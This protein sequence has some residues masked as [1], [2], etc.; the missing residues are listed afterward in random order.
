M[1][2]I[3]GKPVARVDARAKVTGA[4]V[5]TV[6]VVRPG[7]VHAAI[8][9]SERAHA[10]I[11]SIDTTE[12]A[13][14]P[15]V[16]GVFT[17]EHLR[18][19]DPYY[20]HIIR[21]HPVLAVDKVRFMGE[22]IAIVVASTRLTARAAAATVT[23]EYEDLEPVIGIDDAVRD[24]APLVHESRYRRGT[25]VAWETVP[26]DHLGT[27]V[28]HEAHLEWGDV[29]AALGA[30]DLTV[31]TTGTYPMLYA[32]AM[33]PYAAV[34]EYRG[35]QLHVVS[36]TQ[37]P[38]MVR[39]EL[40]RIF[41]VPH[42]QVQVEAP[43]VGGG[44]GSKSWTKV[45][46]LAAV[47]AHLTG[48]AVRIGLTVEE[49]M[50]TTRADSARVIVST[51]LTSDGAIMARDFQVDFNTGAYADSSPSILDKAV[52]RCFGP[53]RIPNLRIH[54]RLLYTNTVPASS[55]RG[56]GAPQGNLAGEYNLDHA[57]HKLGIDPGQLRRRNLAAKGDELLPKRRPLDADIAADLDLLLTS[58]QRDPPQVDAP[59]RYG[60]GFGC[61]ASD[62]GAFPTSTAMVRI[63]PDGSVLVS[64]GAVEIGQGS[65]TVLSQIVA[66]ELGL[67]MDAVAIAQSSTIATPFERTT[68]GSRTTTLVGLAVLR[69]A[70][71]ALADLRR[72]AAEVWSCGIDLVVAS[73]GAL[74]GP[75]GRAAGYGDVVTSWFGI[76]GGEAI[77][78]GIVRPEGETKAMPPFWEIGVAG[79]GLLVD[80]ETG[81]VRVE[82]LAT[83]G[84]VGFAINP[85][86]MEGQDLG[87]AT[88]GLGAALAE[89]LEYDGG[90]LTNPNLVDYRVPRS[91]DMPS[92]I[93]T[94]LAQR[95]D[96][97][98]PYGAKGGGEGS[99]NPI[100][101]AVMSAIARATGVWPDDVELPMT[102]E[103]VWRLMRGSPDGR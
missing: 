87:A 7:M 49:A 15:D 2:R 92:I 84:D 78:I 42:S 70:Q 58:L 9:R 83:V 11:R 98:G 20:G 3:V 59:Y 5:Y 90:Q 4:A 75:D 72:M 19:L 51:G 43:Y 103:R 67:P 91:T 27:N 96:G 94:I 88:Q 50:L 76:D 37:H 23:V 97:V 56:F 8:V 82:R 64:S 17:A 40:A 85:A 77:G 18:H 63:G 47:A 1:S 74:C 100:G 13:G 14:S 48:R 21:D 73:D 44:Y 53:Y 45:E 99:L 102:P 80:G 46:P 86:A 38:F 26:D 81:Q 66:E 31:R 36:S 79:V 16:I 32:Y 55:Y 29:E 41:Q 52:H 57:A 101:G 95:Q 89:Q 54:A 39:A 34:A 71:A 35:G 10:F 61:S 33:E 65:A 24:G 22:P 12:A 62:A 60:I 69:A 68:N 28:A 30:A 93:D 6:D 25:G